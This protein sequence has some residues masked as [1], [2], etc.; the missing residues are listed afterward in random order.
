[1]LGKLGLVAAALYVLFFLYVMFHMSM[2]GILTDPISWLFAMWAVA[3]VVFV[4]WRGSKNRFWLCALLPL[5]LFGIYMGYVMGFVSTSSTTALGLIF[6][7]LFQWAFVGV[8][9]I[10]KKVA[11]S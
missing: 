10:V 5:L 2:G 9:L 3:P 4:A 8:A 6:L 11:K 7:P 1:M